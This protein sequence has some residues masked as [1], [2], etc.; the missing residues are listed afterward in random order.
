[1]SALDSCSAAV[2]SVAWDPGKRI[3]FH[4]LAAF[5]PG[6]SPR[7]KGLSFG[8]DYDPTK[9]VLDT[10]GSCADFEVADGTWPAPGTGT[11]QSW[12]TGAQTGLLTE[13]YWLVGYTYSEQEGEDSTLVA[14]IPHPRHHGVFV[15]DGFPAEVDTVAGYGRL[16]FGMAG[17]LPCPAGGGDVV[18]VPE[19]G[20]GQPGG[21][22][23]PGDEGGSP[24]EASAPGDLTFVELTAESDS[25]YGAA[26]RGLKRDY[27]LNVLLGM[28]PDG[29]ICRMDESQRDALALDE[30]VNA[31]TD[32]IVS[33]RSGGPQPGEP[34][35][36]ALVWNEM[37]SSSPPESLGNG[38]AFLDSV[39]VEQSEPGRNPPTRDASKQ[40]SL[41]LLGDVGVSLIFMESDSS[42]TCQQ[43]NDAEDWTDDEILDT[44]YRVNWGLV[45]LGE[46]SP[47]ATVA[48][49]LEYYARVPTDVE[50]IHG[51]IANAAWLHDAMDYLNIPSNQYPAVRVYEFNNRR[52]ANFQSFCDWWFTTF[53]IDDS[54]DGD[55]FFDQSPG[56]GG[57]A[58]TYGP[59][60]IVLSWIGLPNNEQ[61]GR[62][63]VMPATTHETCH[64]FGAGDEYTGCS[65]CSGHYGYLDVQHGNC[66]ACRPNCPPECADPPLDCQ[67]T[68]GW[69][70]P[71]HIC[72]YTRGQI[73]WRDLDSPPDSIYDPIDHLDS[74]RFMII[75]DGDPLAPGDSVSIY[76]E[77][78]SHW[79]KRLSAS[80]RGMDQ[81]LMLWDGI[82][83]NGTT[84]PSYESYSWSRDEGTHH[85]ASLV[86]D[87]DSADILQAEIRRGNFPRYTDTL[88]VRFADEESHAARVRATAIETSTGR[89]N[90]VIKDKF[91]QET[92]D[93]EDAIVQTFHLEEGVWSMR[94]QVWATGGGPAAVHYVPFV[95][96]GVEN[97]R[98]PMPEL[99][100]SSG[101][102]NPSA[103]WVTW[104]LQQSHGRKVSLSII[105][106]DGRCVKSWS[107]QS[108][109]EGTTRILWDGL[110]AR[111]GRVVSGRYFLV[112]TDGTGRRVGGAATMVR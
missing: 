7:V 102:P 41:Y 108:V 101:R 83:W 29:L 71:P 18:W 91:Y 12:T 59:Y 79:V 53:L 95:V 16:G 51:S 3:V 92:D 58:G 97:A 43:P 40:T 19:G 48:W 54:C 90:I 111:G 109:A 26:Y 82:N 87:A 50:P 5:P 24:T 69:Y 66:A 47:S 77:P 1:M 96:A 104:N 31:V 35:F 81:G 99:K 56:L 89:Q 61:V 30:R 39:I 11:A 42:S 76:G 100:L 94:V 38:E 57:L 103:S 73:G 85:N 98:A 44:A 2:T 14:L 105:G 20:E 84:S 75:G 55:H 72:R 63:R 52:R 86:T 70:W 60:S 33:G 107:E 93:P 36:A 65:G 4:V 62:D 25:A 49:H 28:I 80:D 68:N 17:A 13:A 22:E 10:R 112:V 9:L 106:V 32:E 8:I 6:S 46:Q 67:M 74:D 110:D 37:L 21:S 64:V 23:P 45:R 15:D 34:G 88:I 78:G 27:G